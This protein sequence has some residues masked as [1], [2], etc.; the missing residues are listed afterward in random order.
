MNAAKDKK[1]ANNSI[2]LKYNE[3]LQKEALKELI[4]KYAEKKVDDH[5]AK[6]KVKKYDVYKS[7][8]NNKYVDFNIK[9]TY[10]ESQIEQ[11]LGITK[12][13]KLSKQL[14]AAIKASRALIN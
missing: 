13:N 8:F 10:F 11:N 6:L 2:Q 12:P 1:V 5:R 4:Y 3:Y 9:N 14:L 7:K